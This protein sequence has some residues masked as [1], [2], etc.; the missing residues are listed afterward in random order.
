MKSSCYT[1][2]KAGKICLKA[3][4]CE[5]DCLILKHFKET[6][7]TSEGCFIYLLSHAAFKLGYL[8]ASISYSKAIINTQEMG[9]L[10]ERAPARDFTAGFHRASLFLPIPALKKRGSGQEWG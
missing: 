8:S 9:K 4:L 6:I 3:C 2:G 1:A 5:T 10:G 7:N